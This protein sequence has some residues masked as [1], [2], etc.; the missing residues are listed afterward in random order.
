MKS[1]YKSSNSKGRVYKFTDYEI[2]FYDKTF[3]VTH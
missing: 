3:E 2:K 1:L